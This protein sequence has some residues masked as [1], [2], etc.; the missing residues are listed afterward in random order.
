MSR[1]FIHELITHICKLISNQLPVLL[2]NYKPINVHLPAAGRT[3]RN[4]GTVGGNSRAQ[5]VPPP[6]KISCAPPQSYYHTFQ[7]CSV[8]AQT[9]Q[10]GNKQ[11]IQHLILINNPK[12]LCLHEHYVQLNLPYPHSLFNEKNSIKSHQVIKQLIS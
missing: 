1:G 8:R 7:Y 6:G 4:N 5:A 2:T 3:D 9:V 10:S 12:V 11:L